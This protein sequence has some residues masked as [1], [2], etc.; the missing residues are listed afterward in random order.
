[1]QP[2]TLRSCIIALWL[3]CP[4]FSVAQNAI[5]LSVEYSYLKH[6]KWETLV[7][8]Y[9]RFFDTVQQ[10]QPDLHH[11]PGACLVYERKMSEYFYVQ[12]YLQYQ[13]AQ[14]ISSNSGKTLALKARV[15]G[16]G[17]NINWYPVKMVA[18]RKKTVF[19]PLYLRIGIGVSYLRNN[20]TLDNQP[21]YKDPANSGRSANLA[22]LAESGLGYDLH[23]G[24]RLVFQSFFG[25]RLYPVMGMQSME[26]FILKMKR[27]DLEDVGFAM[28]Y[29]A[30]FTLLF[31]F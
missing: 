18:G 30:Q 9:N 4:F 31:L 13:Q 23:F 27:Y 24:K 12:P 7:S 28:A 22:V 11:L 10:K 5:G 8:E 3:F 15:F 2:H 25:A 21:A 20:I 19:N 6:K 14:T 1:M 29:K 16:A 26:Y 17:A